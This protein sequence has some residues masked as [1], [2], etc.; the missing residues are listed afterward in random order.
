MI[1]VSSDIPG[2][3]ELTCINFDFCDNKRHVVHFI[4]VLSPFIVSGKLLVKMKKKL[5]EKKFHFD[6]LHDLIFRVSMVHF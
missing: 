2:P 3:Y 4:R 5:S 6:I 1:K